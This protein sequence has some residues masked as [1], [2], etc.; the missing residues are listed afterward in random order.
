MKTGRHKISVST[1][2]V[3]HYVLWGMLQQFL[4]IKSGCYNK[5][6]CYNECGRILSADIARA[7]AWCVGPSRF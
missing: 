7:C 2:V 1:A 4:S 5:H 6:R 3:L